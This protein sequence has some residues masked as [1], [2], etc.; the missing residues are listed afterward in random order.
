MVHNARKVYDAVCL[1]RKEV[2]LSR[3][4]AGALDAKMDRLPVLRRFRM[5]DELFG[6]LPSTE[7]PTSGVGRREAV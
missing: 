5:D 4:E 1:K 6:D 7:D 2:E 3:D